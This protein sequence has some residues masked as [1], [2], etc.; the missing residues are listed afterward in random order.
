MNRYKL[1][2]KLLEKDYNNRK[3]K[4]KQEQVVQTK[5]IP[6]PKISSVLSN[7]KT[8][9]EYSC[10]RCHKPIVYDI[11]F[12]DDFTSKYI[13][14]DRETMRTHFRNC[15][16]SRVRNSHDNRYG[17]TAETIATLQSSAMSI[18]KKDRPCMDKIPNSNLLGYGH[19]I[20][21]FPTK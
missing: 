7:L 21:N 5:T 19:E 13:P 2:T 11:L 16:S 15:K 3:L 9:F 12:V 8:R 6:K 18:K 1:Y 4:K 14:L 17:K 10:D 20:Y